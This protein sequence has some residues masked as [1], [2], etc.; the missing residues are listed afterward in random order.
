MTARL[1][2]RFAKLKTQ[3]RAA[4]IA[5]IMGGDPNLKESAALLAAMPEAGADIIELGF[6]F[7][8]PM[9][10][11]PVIQAAAGRSLEAGTTLAKTLKL[12]SDFRKKDK[13]TP[14]ILM[15]YYNPVLQFGSDKLVKEALKAGVDGLLIVDLPPEEDDALIK[16]ANKGKLAII[17][18][19][20]PTTTP[21][22]AK[23]VLSKAS[24]FLYYVSITGITGAKTADF[25]KVKK[26]VTALKSK[27]K[28]PIAVGFGIKTPAD[29]KVVGGFAD[30]VVVG[31]ALVKEVAQNIGKPQETI[32]KVTASLRALSLAL[33]D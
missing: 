11:G 19:A 16:A 28:L 10:D 15:G 24:G 21:E 33:K 14:I 29:A 32:R 7:S 8:D 2:A 25:G 18:L 20:A 30:A 27:T 22:R 31:S 4:L 1:D 6:P 17:K 9:A 3:K 23:T 5:Y 13:E 26:A 12:V